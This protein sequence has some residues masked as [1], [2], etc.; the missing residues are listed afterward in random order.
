VETIEQRLPA[1]E[2]ERT[3]K[4]QE[5]ILKAMAGKLKW[6]EAA[7]IIGVTDRT[8]RRWRERYQEHG[9]SGL[10]DYRKRSPSPKRVPVAQLEEVLQLYR[11]KYF[12]FNVRHFHEKLTEEHGIEFSYTWVKT[13]LQEAG[14]VARRKKRGSHRKRRP[15]RAMPGMMLHIDGS[16]H[17][18]FGDER[19]YELISILDDATSEIYYAQLAEAES[20][21]TVMAALR[22]VIETKGVFC[23][24]YSDRAGHFFVTL[25]RGE[26]VDLSRP[27]QVGRALQELGIKM[28][29]AYSP[30]A[31][32]RMERSYGTWQGRLP[33]EFRLREITDVDQANEF[34]QTQYIAEFNR[35]FS[36]TAAQKGSAFVRLRRTD[37][38]R[39]FSV[40]HERTVA[41]DNTVALAN[42]V[43]QLEK[44][45]WRN[46]L[47]GQN[48]IV[49]EHLDGRVSIRYGPHVIAEY[50]ANQLPAA[51]SRGYPWAKPPHQTRRRH[52]E[53]S[54]V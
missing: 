32:G 37:L 34:L 45:R 49:H 10:W 7:E 29:P 8:M 18:W 38:D 26:R 40:Q 36:V 20:T 44:T 25:K 19:R 30:Q 5:V 53:R 6:W 46:T 27:T 16:E 33:Q 35:R 48:V 9:Y 54:I 51:A 52:S 50:A 11:D 13:V 21:R 28:I 47:A 15:R 41:N 14:L 3:M 31:R 2:L 1:A 39:I 24:L 22:Y 43:F 17:R 23:S 12:D 4:I 42:R